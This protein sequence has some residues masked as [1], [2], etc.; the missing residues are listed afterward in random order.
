M[1]IA[2]LAGRLVLLT[3]AGAVDVE[4]ASG[5]RFAADPHTVYARWDEFTAWAAEA[6]T[7]DAEAFDEGDLRAPSPTPAQVFGVGLNYREHAAESGLG[8]PDSPAVFTKFPSCL[9]G[10]TGEITLTGS[11]VDWE[12]ELVAVIGRE[13]RN[14]PA[15]RGWAHV[16][17]LTAGQDLSDR[18]VQLAG[19]APQFSLGKSAPGFGPTGPWLVTP[20]EFADRDNLA[21]SSEVNGEAVQKGRTNDLIFSVPELVAR[22][23]AILPLRP[24]DVIFTGTPSG[25]GQARSPQRFLAAGDELVTTIEGI[26][27]MRHRFTDPS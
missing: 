26:G 11:T 6:P 24:G 5:Q 25:V 7:A 16:A 9:T 2:N 27:S 15:E 4:R 1:R 12:V 17:G 10:P 3:E 23:S 18:T 8:L 13:A 14:V 19:P 22:L 21:L 20:D